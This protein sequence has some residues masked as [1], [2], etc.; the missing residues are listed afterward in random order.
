MVSKKRQ[1]NN[2]DPVKRKLAMNSLSTQQVAIKSDKEKELTA[3]EILEEYQRGEISEDEA[4]SFFDQMLSRAYEPS[5]ID[6]IF[7]ELF[8][9]LRKTRMRSSRI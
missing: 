5:L 2:L 6:R 9:S 4:R 1:K 8:P 3:Q 7:R